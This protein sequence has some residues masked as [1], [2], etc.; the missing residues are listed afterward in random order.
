M[1]N[2]AIINPLL[3]LKSEPKPDSIT[4]GGKTRKQIKPTL[5][6]QKNLL[7]S[8][9]KE[10]SRKI[11]NQPT[12]ANRTHL[13][14]KM[15]QDSLAPTLTPNDLFS[16]KNNA[17]IIA[18]AYQ[19]YLV[20][21]LSSDIDSLADKI[22]E[23]DKTEEQVDISRIHSIGV[24]DRQEVLRGKGIEDL[25]DAHK[26]DKFQAFNIWLMP[27]KDIKAREE[28]VLKMRSLLK[29]EE[30]RFGDPEF[31]VN[32]SENTGY[33][34]LREYINKGYSS[35]S[36][37][38][39][40]K[41]IIE[42]IISSGTIYRIDP[43]TP[44]KTTTEPGAGKEPTPKKINPDSPTVVMIDGGVN[45]KSYLPL[46]RLK[47][48]ELVSNNYADLAH[49][50][51]V[52]SLIC[53]AHAW[54]NNRPIPKLDCTFISAQAICK[55]SAPKSPNNSQLVDY[56][57]E[58]AR[59]TKKHSRV[60]NLSFNQTIKNNKT[61]EVSYLGHQ[62]SKISR[63]H[64][65]L[66]IISI[67]NTD[68]NFIDSS[69]CPP[70]DCE[71]ALT[72]SARNFDNKNEL[73]SASDYSLHGPGPAGM[74]KPDLSWFGTLRVIGGI[75]DKG[76]SFSTPLVSSLAAHAFQEIK[77]STPDLVRAI[78]I[79]RADLNEHCQRLGWGTPVTNEILPWHCSSDSV[80]LAWT[81]KLSTGSRY[82]WDDIPIPS[83]LIE[84]HK[85]KGTVVL[86]AILNPRVSEIGGDN[87]FASRL[88]TSLQAPRGDK[89]ISLVGSM[90]ESKVDEKKAR[91]D[92]AKWSPVR[93][94]SKVHKTGTAI[95]GDKVRVYARVFTRD[96]YQFGDNDAEE[97]HEVAFVLTFQAN[98]TGKD[99]YNT[100]VQRLDSSVEIALVEQ[101]IDISYDLNN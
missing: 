65:I 93:H 9:L 62:I 1:P 78:L 74:I 2:K 26:K 95:S 53:H 42:K 3:R 51:K 73:G 10:I 57:E 11:D 12:F 59:K 88:E 19:G 94:H 44:I 52:A 17:R 40:S 76:T 28:L 79:N 83:E 27:F 68:H 75:V 96:Q 89:F 4:G 5:I 32:K 58:V 55:S 56:L 92:L 30:V 50:N 23:T 69:L 99:I 16:H 97:Q 80:T 39:K 60:W 37:E 47:V 71:S 85:F 7:S 64:G 46:E 63:K 66:P 41:D 13:I 54:N 36:I 87:Y 31:T 35:I 8:Q 98:D 91:R 81:A 6:Q 29:S 15:Q 33:E 67:G 24:F 34:F 70:A 20:E 77:N 49:G 25:W 45:A 38:T 82:Y 100:M 22:K 43:C 48:P 90:R 14:A 101:D 61:D 72:I 84:N 86:T 18:P 21:I